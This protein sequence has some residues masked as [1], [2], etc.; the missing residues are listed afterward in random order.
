[1]SL[2]IIKLFGHCKAATLIFISALG[3]TMSCTQEGRYGYI[4]V[5][6]DDKLFGPRRFARIS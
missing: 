6:L 2:V 4:S 3:S 5:N 1:M